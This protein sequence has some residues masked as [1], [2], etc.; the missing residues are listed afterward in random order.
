MNGSAIDNFDS[1]CM[2]FVE[3]VACEFDFWRI[4]DYEGVACGFLKLIWLSKR[5]HLVLRVLGNL[6]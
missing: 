6:V 4:D 1:G 2:G 5:L 3:I